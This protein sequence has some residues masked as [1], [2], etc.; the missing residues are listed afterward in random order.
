M[1]PFDYSFFSFLSTHDKHHRQQPEEPSVSPEQ[2]PVHRYGDMTINPHEVD[3]ANGGGVRVFPDS[4]PRYYNP[5]SAYY[6][7]IAAC[8]QK[9]IDENTP[10]P[11]TLQQITQKATVMAQCVLS[12]LAQYAYLIIFLQVMLAGSIFA[13][14]VN[15]LMTQRN[16][17]LSQQAQAIGIKTT[18]VATAA[19]QA[20]DTQD[21]SDIVGLRVQTKIAHLN[22]IGQENQQLINQATQLQQK[23]S[24]LQA[25]MNKV[26]DSTS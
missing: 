1:K 18:A 4:V 26:K 6:K 24:A 19:I 25:K 16:T 3:L 15:T 17:Q 22:A 13:A 8:A 21:L 20:K 7:A 12:W 14:Q 5:D 11:T 9:K 2:K 23:I 10:E